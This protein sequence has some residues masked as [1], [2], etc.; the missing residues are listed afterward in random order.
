MKAQPSTR[1]ERARCDAARMRGQGGHRLFFAA[2][3]GPQVRSRI[4]AAAQAL[5]RDAGLR[6]R[7]VR[8]E[9]LHLTLH[10]LG[11]VPDGG[12]AAALAAAAAVEAPRFELVLDRAGGFERARVA[13]LGCTSVPLSLLDLHG[14]LRDALL[15]RGLPVESR[16]YAPHVTVQ[17]DVRMR[18]PEVA[19]EPVAWA[20]DAFALIDSRPDRGYVEVGRW[21][22]RG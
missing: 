2:W 4:D 7:R 21:P 14:R 17:R 19:V 9:R 12:L 22:L 20:V 10:F 11:A 13:W 5:A 16:A 18:V 1:M 8:A 6:G 15:E 3:P